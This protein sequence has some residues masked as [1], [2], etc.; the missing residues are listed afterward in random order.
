MCHMLSHVTAF[1]SL[2]LELPRKKSQ[3]SP[4]TRQPYH[5]A[6]YSMEGYKREKQKATKALVPPLWTKERSAPSWFSRNFH[7][8]DRRPPSF[9]APAGSQAGAGNSR[10]NPTDLMA[11]AVERRASLHAKQALGLPLFAA[12]GGVGRRPRGCAAEGLLARA[13]AQLV[14]GCL[15]LMALHPQ[16]Q[17]L[18]AR[19]LTRSWPCLS[20]VRHPWR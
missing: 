14:T 3:P 18:L 13:S 4:L 1:Q 8:D 5:Y 19:L 10:Q 7:E 20:T 11:Q 12:Q 6:S 9:H 17:Q 16:H 15:G 2:Q